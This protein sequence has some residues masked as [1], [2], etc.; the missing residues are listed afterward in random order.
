MKI[1]LE[2]VFLVLIILFGLFIRVYDL[3]VAPLWIDESTSAMASKMILEKGVPV[4]DSGYAFSR[5][6]VFHY[7]Q[8]GIMGFGISDFSARFISVIFGLLTILLG[9]FIGKE[10]SKSGGVI[11]ALFLSV[12]YLEVVFSR[13]ARMYQLFQLMFFLSLYLLYKSREKNWLI[14]P[15]LVSLYV[16]IDTQIA[17]LVLCPFFILFMLKYTKK[18]WLTV[19]P[20]IPLIRKFLSLFGLSSGGDSTLVDNY[21]SSYFSF[22]SSMHYLIVLFIV[23]CIWAFYHKKLLTLLL[24]IPAL[25]LLIGIF[26]LQ[27]FALRYAYFFVFILVLYGSLL[28]SFLYEKYG[29]F[30]LVSLLLVLIVPSTLFFPITGINVFTLDYSYYDP[31]APVT[32]YK[33]LDEALVLDLK[34][35]TLVSLFSSDVEWYIKKP[36]YVIPFSMDGRGED[37]ISY[38]SSNL[39]VDRY[40]GALILDDSFV[41]GYVLA[42]SFSFSKL[43]PNQREEFENLVENCDL[44]KGKRDLRIYYC[45]EDLKSD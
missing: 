41:S 27:T 37:Q 26:N 12:F 24:V 31:T 7:M 45:Q 36:D 22:A 39:V 6:N 35:S 2:I 28:L 43:K 9:Y 38:N 17:G 20:L 15:A 30:M 44:V 1:K 10:Y 14:Y 25:T 16:T 32:D 34:S 33:N 3:G 19:I 4:F 23:G 18:R 40:S 13:Q 11:V 29:K 8:A 42:D 21:I 5:A